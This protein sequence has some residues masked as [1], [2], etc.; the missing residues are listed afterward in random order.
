MYKRQLPSWPLSFNPEQVAVPSD[1]RAQPA[2][3]VSAETCTTV[4]IAAPAGDRPA[5]VIDIV[6]IDAIRTT[7]DARVIWH[8]SAG[9]RAP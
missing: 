3:V 9:I 1:I 8:P 6:S 4:A 7:R 2:C 5:A